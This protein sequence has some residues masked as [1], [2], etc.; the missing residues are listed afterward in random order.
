VNKVTAQEVLNRIDSFCKEYRTTHIIPGYEFEHVVLGDYNLDR[1]FFESA[2]KR[3]PGWKEEKLKDAQRAK[4]W[5]TDSPVYTEFELGL[6][7]QEIDAYAEAAMKF[8]QWLGTIPEQVLIDAE[9]LEHGE[10]L[11][12]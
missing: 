1:D 9:W 12:D 5:M 3:I 8:L 2:I 7:K 10:C 4:D 6:I 11:C